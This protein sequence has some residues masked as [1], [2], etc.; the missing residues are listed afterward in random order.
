MKNNNIHFFNILDGDT[1][2]KSIEKFNY[3]LNKE[4]YMIIKDNIFIGSLY[5]FNNTI[6]KSGRIQFV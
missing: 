3:L 2:Y 6:I 4:K 1:C 5:D